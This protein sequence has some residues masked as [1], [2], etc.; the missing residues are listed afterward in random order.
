MLLLPISVLLHPPCAVSTLVV[1]LSE[2]GLARALQAPALTERSAHNNCVAHTNRDRLVMDLGNTSD[3]EYSTFAA[4]CAVQNPQEHLGLPA[5]APVQT[6]R[7]GSLSTPVSPVARRYGAE[8][9]IEDKE[10]THRDGRA[11]EP[12]PHGGRTV[13]LPGSKVRTPQRGVKIF[14]HEPCYYLCEFAGE[15]AFAN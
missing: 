8:P 9:A 11:N 3:S 15:H 10:D 5:L 6:A 14:S 4:P 2:G 13:V 1:C 12:I 7:R